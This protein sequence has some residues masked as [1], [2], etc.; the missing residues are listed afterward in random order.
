MGIYCAAAIYRA[1]VCQRATPPASKPV[2][3][4]FSPRHGEAIYDLLFV[5]S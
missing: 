4:A 2:E 1:T 3:I 5:S